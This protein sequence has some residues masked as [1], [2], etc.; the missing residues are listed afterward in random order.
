METDLDEL[1]ARTR[2]VLRAHGIRKAGLYGSRVRGD[3]SA[4]SDLDVVIESPEAF[5]LYDLVALQHE[6]TE[7]LGVQAHVT[8]YRSLHPR[9]R[10]EI[11]EGELRLFG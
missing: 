5:S 9:L 11:L 3:H 1:R 2:A 6:L 4:A 8:T 7:A 10:G